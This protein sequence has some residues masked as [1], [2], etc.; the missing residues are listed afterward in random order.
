M[1]EFNRRVKKALPY[2]RLHYLNFWNEDV[3]SPT[4]WYGVAIQLPGA[5]EGK[6]RSLAEFVESYKEL[7]ENVISNLD[8]GSSWVVNHD[9]EDMNWFPNHFYM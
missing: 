8:N 5:Y 4:Q 7:L 9:Q 2:N 6:V 3:V 1:I